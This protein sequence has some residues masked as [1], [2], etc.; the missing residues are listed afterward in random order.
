MADQ[1]ERDAAQSE[2][3]DYERVRSLLP[4]LKLERAE[5]EQVKKDLNAARRSWES[6]GYGKAAIYKYLQ[7]VF[8]IG[9]T[10]FNERKGVR[11]Q[12]IMRALTG[13]DMGTKLRGRFRTILI[14]YL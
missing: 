8:D 9:Q 5:V 11:Y 2:E 12:A 13:F 3:P 10:W 4:R 1:G 7:T 6:K 14:L